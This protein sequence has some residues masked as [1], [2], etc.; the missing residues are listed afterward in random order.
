M[1]LQLLDMDL[2]SSG[3]M[4]GMCLKWFK[5]KR[6]RQNGNGLVF[7]EVALFWAKMGF[8]VLEGV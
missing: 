8:S 5:A 1:R 7:A 6:T 3:V 4:Y 2:D